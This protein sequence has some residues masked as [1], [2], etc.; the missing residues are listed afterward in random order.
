MLLHACV[1]VI[2]CFGARL[3]ESES[4]AGG[5]PCA[6]NESIYALYAFDVREE[7]MGESEHDA[8]RIASICA[9]S[10]FHALDMET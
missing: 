9:F 4:S 1:L 2:V 5:H 8:L 3:F 7:Y 6:W 10:M